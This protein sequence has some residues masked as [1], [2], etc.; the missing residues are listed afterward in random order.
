MRAASAF[1]PARLLGVLV[2]QPLLDHRV[3]GG[4]GRPLPIEQERVVGA[5]LDRPTIQPRVAVR[6][7]PE[8]DAFDFI[9]VLQKQGENISVAFCQFSLLATRLPRLS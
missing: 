6:H 5:A 3:E 7:A 2:V 4:L 8:C 9:F 1:G